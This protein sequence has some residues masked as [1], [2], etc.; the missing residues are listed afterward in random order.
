M[1]GNVGTAST[2]L[3]FNLYPAVVIDDTLYT[4]GSVG[5]NPLLF[6]SVYDDVNLYWSVTT[7]GLL[8]V[9]GTRFIMLH[10]DELEDHLYGSYSYIGNTPGI[11]FFKQ[12]A[13]G[14]GISNLRFDF[15]SVVQRPFH[16]IGKLSSI[17]IRFVDQDN[18]AY[19]F[20]AINHQL[21]F[22]VKFYMPTPK[23][24][25]HFDNQILN[26]NYNP[27]LMQYLAANK[28]MQ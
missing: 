22:Q 13:P 4:A 6:V 5:T 7:P 8:D 28:S 9:I 21:L 12:G 18:V 3:G 15:T 16:P 23:A 2:S 19:D 27:D 14:G 10:V 24:G 1:N 11:G 20:K 17:S 26:P 25:V